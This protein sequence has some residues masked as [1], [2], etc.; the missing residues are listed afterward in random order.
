MIG[1]IW[2][3][4]LLGLAM[5]L[6]GTAG[7]RSGRMWKHEYATVNGVKLHY[8]TQ[9]HGQGILF[10]HGFPE[11][12][13]AWKDQI[14]EFGKTHRAIAL[15]MRGYNL[16]EK[17]P[18]VEDYALTTLV[19]DIKAFLE[20]VSRGRKAILVAHDWGGA[21]AWVYAAQYPETLEKLVIINAPHPT[22]F[23]RELQSN[24][25]QQQA[26][27]YMNFFRS[28]GAEQLLS[29]NHYAALAQAVFGGSTKPDSFTEEDRSAYIAAWSQPGAL[30]GGLN[31][32]RAAKI[33]PPAPGSPEK[34]GF[35]GPDLPAVTVPTLVIWG[36]K[37]TALLTGNLD[38]LDKFVPQL[39]IKRIPTGSHWVVH[40]EP[41]A[42]NTAIHEFLK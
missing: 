29:A 16:S 39:T 41:E 26:S 17:P 11:F 12:W 14:P 31:Y 4:A 34:P 30:T 18:K 38:G 42:I 36:E 3:L 2:W 8:V 40:E 15:D 21:I 35:A 37:D 7:A 20:K 28:A 33:G 19:A 32:Y 25:A 27:G 1:R 22:V 6:P 23:S 9:G 10:L 24:P 5:A 13:Y